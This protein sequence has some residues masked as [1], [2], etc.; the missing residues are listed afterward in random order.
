MTLATYATHISYTVYIIHSC[1]P[2]VCVCRCASVHCDMTDTSTFTE[3]WWPLRLFSQKKNLRNSREIP[4]LR[5]KQWMYVMERRN[6]CC[7]A[8]CITFG[9]HIFI[10][11]SFPPRNKTRRIPISSFFFVFI[12]FPDIPNY[13]NNLSF[14]RKNIEAIFMLF[15]SCHLG[16]DVTFF[17]AVTKASIFVV[18]F[19]FLLVDE[20]A[21]SFSPISV[22]FTVQ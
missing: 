19:F 5:E 16:L 6:C 14:P 20:Y 22:F 12:F 11:L 1:L 7:V 18:V 21:L 17:Q 9:D 4:R 13:L 3:F 10:A 15:Q 8:L 2:Y